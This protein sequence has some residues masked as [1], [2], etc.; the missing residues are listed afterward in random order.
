MGGTATGAAPSQHRAWLP[1]RPLAPAMP[2]ALHVSQHAG[3]GIYLD[4]DAGGMVQTLVQ[5]RPLQGRRRSLKWGG[6]D[7]SPGRV[8]HPGGSAMAGAAGR[9]P[10]GLGLHQASPKCFR[11][12]PCPKELAI[13]RSAQ[14]EEKAMGAPT[15]I[16]RQGWWE[17]TCI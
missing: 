11:A 4:V 1:Y 5:K 6:A 3:E 13:Q 16:A 15:P 10:R 12:V 2:G 8:G 7:A 17:A 14:M 9:E